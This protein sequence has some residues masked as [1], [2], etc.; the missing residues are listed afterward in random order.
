LCG[1]DYSK[2]V[3]CFRFRYTFPATSN[4]NKAK[5]QKPASVPL[6][7]GAL[8]KTGSKLSIKKVPKQVLFRWPEEVRKRN[9]KVL[10]D[11]LSQSEKPKEKKKK[12]H[13]KGEK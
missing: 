11:R 9:K 3:T 2:I 12:K 1:P 10:G 5:T 4:E 7:S 6:G 8:R 13:T